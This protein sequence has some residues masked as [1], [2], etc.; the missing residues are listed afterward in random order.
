MISF[1]RAG[2]RISLAL[3]MVA[4]GASAADIGSV[5]KVKVGSGPAAGTHTL[6]DNRTCT[7]G[8][9]DNGRVEL[10]VLLLRDDEIAT[11]SKTT[12]HD[13]II[14]VRSLLDPNRAGELSFDLVFTP[15]QKG[16][17]SSWKIQAHHQVD[18]RPD[19][20]LLRY[21]LEERGAGKLTGRGGFKYNKAAEGASPIATLQFW[22]VTQ[23]GVRIDGTVECYRVDGNW[24][25]GRT[26]SA[27]G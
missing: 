8:K 26:E 12:L 14:S 24:L 18:T 23:E 5:V 11:N 19:S 4:A 25:R 27:P 2:K 20:V 10:E 6:T 21:E 3:A 16:P 15:R 13:V 9:G 17:R 7:F 22:G 1:K